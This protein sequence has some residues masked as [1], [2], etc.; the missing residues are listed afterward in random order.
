MNHTKMI[1]WRDICVFLETAQYAK[2]YA[3]DVYDVDPAME[4]T[5]VVPEEVCY[6]QTI[7]ALIGF[8]D[9]AIASQT[10]SAE[11]TQ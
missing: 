5:A 10:A 8:T 9:E 11:G 7:Q 2:T 4:Y 3:H 6:E 1:N